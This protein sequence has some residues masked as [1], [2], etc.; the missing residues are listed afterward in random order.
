MKIVFMGTPDFAVPTLKKIYSSGFKIPLV[1]T[2]PD[3]KKGRGKKLQAPPVKITAEELGLNVQ[4]PISINEQSILDLLKVIEP[5][6]IVVVAYGQI[7]S[8]EILELPKYGCINVHASLLP[9][10]RGAAPINWAIINGEE[11]TGVTIMQMDEGLDTGD[12]LAQKSIVININQTLGD[13]HDKLSELGADK[14]IEVLNKLP[15]GIDNIPQEQSLAGYAQKIE[16]EIEK[17]DWTKSAFEIHN[18]IRGLSPWP[19]AYTRLSDENIKV[20]TSE[21]VS[22]HGSKEKP[23][24]IVK[25]DSIEGVDVQA[26]QGIVRLLE[27]QVPG[28]KR[29]VVSEFLKGKPIQEGLTLNC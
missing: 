2:Q 9:Q 8:K 17:I 19:G 20:W 1:I 27:L 13:I 14:M 10:Y 24:T 26:G 25:V 16:R 12:I 22:L 29:L 28:K 4:Q 6:V 18:L 11:V 15:D 23:G 3:R 21:I 5:D 7:I